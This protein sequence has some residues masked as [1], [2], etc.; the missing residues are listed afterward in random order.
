MKFMKIASLSAVA[1]I[2]GVSMLAIEPAVLDVSALAHQDDDRNGP[3]TGNRGG[4]RA[5]DVV[6]RSISYRVDPSTGKVHK[7]EQAH[8]RSQGWSEK[9]SRQGA[10]GMIGEGRETGSYAGTGGYGGVGGSTQ[11]GSRQN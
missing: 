5:D 8:H 6:G 11:D 9:N 4:G 3:G 1:L 7:R 10:G 2:A